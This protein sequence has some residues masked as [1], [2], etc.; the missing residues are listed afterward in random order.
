MNGSKN[1]SGEQLRFFYSISP[2]FTLGAD[3]SD[4]KDI[5]ENDEPRNPVSIG[6]HEILT[7]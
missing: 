3:N 7:P 6:R 1:N 5:S 4:L 2:L